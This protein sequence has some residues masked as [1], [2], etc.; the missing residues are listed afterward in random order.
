[1]KFSHYDDGGELSLGNAPP[2]WIHGS[3]IILVTALTF[4]IWYKFSSR[5]F[6]TASVVAIGIV[7]SIFIHEAAHAWAAIKLGHRVVLIRLHVRGGETLWETDRYSRRDDYL[8]TFAGPLANLCAGII[9]LVLYYV[10][11]PDPVSVGTDQLWHR[12][13]PT[14][15]PFIF[16]AIF[17]LSNFNLVLT[18]INLLPAYPLDGG[19]ILHNVLET[20]YGI[21]RALFWTGLAGT[22]LAVISKL[23]FVVSIMGGVLIWSPPNFQV[24]Y[25]AMQAGRQKWPRRVT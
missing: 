16:A 12:P 20:R 18:V 8:V 3:I 17:W 9:G 2:V 1:M 14:S 15:R 11:L 5:G 23:I 10:F 19:H 4:P 13:P 21:H 24:N 25:N 22:I 7:L 6:A